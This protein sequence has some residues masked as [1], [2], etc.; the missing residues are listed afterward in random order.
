MHVWRDY[1]VHRGAFECQGVFT[2]RATAFM[3]SIKPDTSTGLDASSESSYQINKTIKD[4]LGRL[5]EGW[6]V[7]Q[8]FAKDF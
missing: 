8:G 2:I 6:N 7:M 1:Q 3:F 4:Y 5:I